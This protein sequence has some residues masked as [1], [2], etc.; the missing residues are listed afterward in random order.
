MPVQSLAQTRVIEPVLT[1]F[2]YGQMSQ[3]YIAHKICPFVPVLQRACRVVTYHPNDKRVLYPMRRTPGTN[4]QRIGTTY[5]DTLIE[6]YQDAIEVEMTQESIEES[7][8]VVENHWQASIA[9]AKDKMRLRHEVD[10]FSLVNNF[11]GYP[12]TNR[13]ALTAAQQFNNVNVDPVPFFDAANAAVYAGCG[14][15]PNTIV[16]GGLATFNALRNNAR[17]RDQIKYTSNKSVNLAALNDLLGGYTTGL[18]SMSNY[19]LPENQN[20]TPTPIFDKSIWVGYV[21]GNG[22]SS[23]DNPFEIK[24]NMQAEEGADRALP[25]WGYTYLRMAGQMDGS[26][27]TGIIV[28][29][30]YYQANNRAW[31]APMIV[32]RLP[33]VVS[34]GAGYLIANAVA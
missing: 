30:P 2:A 3:G 9:K 11:A 25:A 14:Q 29:Q 23:I 8:F 34:S 16:Y 24:S 27:D 1:Q 28:E 5:G 33:V 22:D 4:I 20:A 12:T 31:Y 18:V 15:M 7:R 19:V 21:P 32:D 13:I 26:R 6:L 17:S 10:V